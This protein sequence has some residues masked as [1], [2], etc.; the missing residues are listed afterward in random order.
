MRSHNRLTSVASGPRLEPGEFVLRCAA[1][2]WIA[3]IGLSTASGAQSASRAQQVVDAA[4]QAASAGALPAFR[5]EWMGARPSSERRL[6]AL[7]L[8]SAARLEYRFPDATSLLVEAEGDTTRPDALAARAALGL[9]AIAMQQFDLRTADARLRRARLIARR[10][11]ARDV[12]AEA[13]VSLV[14]VRQ[15][16]AGVGAAL[17]TADTAA[18]MLDASAIALRI[19]LSC[20]RAQARV[21]AGDPGALADALAGVTDA[22]RLDAPRLE[23]LCWQ[24]AGQSHQMRDEYRDAAIAFGRAAD[25]HAAAH[26]QAGVAASLQ[27][28]GFFRRVIGE[29]DSAQVDYRR[30]IVA[31]TVASNRAPVAWGWLGLSGLSLTSGEPVRAAAEAQRAIRIMTDIGD[32]WGLAS[33]SNL[34]GQA[35]Q[36][37]GDLPRAQM[38]FREA[39]ARSDSLGAISDELL[40]GLRLIDVERELDGEPAALARLAWVDSIAERTGV[41]RWAGERWYHLGLL[42]LRRNDGHAALAHFRRFEQTFRRTDRSTL[43]AFDYTVRLAE[44]HSI[45]GDPLRGARMLDT[46]IERF[47]TWRRGLG[48]RALR[49]ASWEQRGLDPDPDLGIATIIARAAAAGHDSLAFRLADARRARD[50]RSTLETDAAPRTLAPQEALIE[51]VTGLRGEPTTLFIRRG[52][53]V[54]SAR[55]PPI[56]SLMRRIAALQSLLAGDTEAHV[57][58]RELGSVLL[59]PVLS[60]IDRTTTTLVIVPDGALHGVPWSALILPDGGL[61]LDRF[62][63]A[64]L[65][66]GRQLLPAI[67][68]RSGAVVALGAGEATDKWEGQPLAALPRAA[69]EAHFV[70]DLS[71]LG[72]AY[73]GAASTEQVVKRLGAMPPS[74][75]HFAAH[76]IVDDR[77]NA[78]AAIVLHAGDGDDG[79][80]EATEIAALHLPVDLVV[81][82]GCSTASGRIHAAEGVQGLVRPLLDAGVRGVVASQWPVRDESAFRIMQ[83]FYHELAAGNTS[84]DALR[85]ALRHARAAGVP[86]GD[87]ASWSYVGEPGAHVSA[88]FTRPS[89]SRARWLLAAI[90]SAVLVL[91]SIAYRTSIRRV[92]LRT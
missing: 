4:M 3:L 23:G 45:A 27:W 33:A 31:G 59:G 52:S 65:P 12:D 37:L 46:A 56:D 88:A 15:R 79:L 49:L 61:V 77:S 48:E 40:P 53:T 55:L 35:A 67:V 1:P 38:R 54:T 41:S 86:T 18:R 51:Y 10:V 58:A 9:A 66:F 87:W 13:L 21:R 30:A 43:P 91:L 81:L 69:L 72:R 16:L 6:V 39:I 28:R 68:A 89:S 42:A 44:A 57:L 80:F 26:D 32:R 20:R 83:W 29:F 60:R 19:E 2:V 82:A 84:A 92:A 90:A 14:A 50:L 64:L 85:N 76:A 47:A 62:T 25:R 7:A 74:I 24:T 22:A 75:V 63:L 70:A 71:P 34:A 11:N 73:I 78:H 8:G 17:A 5:T 36:Q